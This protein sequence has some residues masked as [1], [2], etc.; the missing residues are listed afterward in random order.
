VPDIAPEY[1]VFSGGFRDSPEW[2]GAFLLAAWQHYLW[3][4]DRA[5]FERHYA[6]MVR[7]VAYLRG[8]LQD[9]LLTHGLGDW[10][11]LG[12]KGPGRSQLT[13]IPLT[14]T[15]FYHEDLKTLATFAGLLGRASEAAAYR[16]EAAQVKAGFNRAFYD[17]AR[18]S[19]ATG[20]QCANALPLV[21][22]LVEPPERPQVVAALVADVQAKGLTAG[23]VGYRYLLRALADAGRSDVVFALTNQTEKPGYGY[24]LAQGATS[25]TESWKAGR[26]SSQNHFMLGQITEWFYHDLAGI[27]PDPAGPGFQKI[28]I[29]PAVVGDLAWVRA[30]YESPRGPVSVA[31]RRTGR[32]FALDVG[33]P[34]NTTATVHVPGETA[35]RTVGSGEHHFTA[36]L[37]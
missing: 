24:Q 28:T 1:V 34:P 17:D 3:S 29:R 8:R 27:Q 9:G 36:Q 5:P 11:D 14:A 30:S 15:A 32:V 6:A 22:D 4:G 19:Y 23:D 31:W 18:G 33:I 10:Y 13:P 26:G 7:Y 35:P 25:L 20:S 21:F 37:P 2:G 16:E 12:P